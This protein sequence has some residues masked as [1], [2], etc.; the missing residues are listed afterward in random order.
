[1]KKLINLEYLV[2]DCLKRDK[3]PTH[4]N[5]EEAINILKF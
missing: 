4:F 1:M 5:Y 3:H 2:I